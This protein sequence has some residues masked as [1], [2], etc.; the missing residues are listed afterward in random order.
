LA[1]CSGIAQGR[2]S[3]YSTGKRAIS[4]TQLTRLARAV[5]L[6]LDVQLR[7]MRISD[8]R[9]RRVLSDVQRR[10]II[11]DLIEL[12]DQFVATRPPANRPLPRPFAELVGRR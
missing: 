3:E 8:P 2:I 5:G 6:D 7:P 4:L 10:Q 12:G 1:R 9:A 11:A